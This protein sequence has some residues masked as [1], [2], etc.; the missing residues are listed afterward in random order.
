MRNVQSMI[1]GVLLSGGVLFLS[2]CSSSKN[3][4]ENIDAEDRFALGKQEFDE[5]DYLDAIRDF[6]IVTIQFQGSA[7]AD[8]AQYYLAESYYERHEY[9]LAASEYETLIRRMR[10]SEL[11]PLAQYKRAMCY[12]KLSPRPAL[13]QQYTK[14]AIDSFQE[15]IEYNPTHQFAPDG[16]ARIQELN[17]KLALK[18]YN[19]ARLYVRMD[20]HKS[21]QFY[22]EH[23]LERYHDSDWADDAHIGLVEVLIARKRYPEANEMVERFFIR[24]PDSPLMIR[25]ENLRNDVNS[26]LN[27]NLD[28]I[29]ETASPSKGKSTPDVDSYFMQNG[30]QKR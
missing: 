25:A 2:S 7:L 3:A 28:Q 17:N 14:K 20:R 30:W 5:G 27:Q 13:D 21:A 9:I 23:L 11:V 8:D 16:E 22:F 29:P 26:K 12:Y 1:V 10:S 19:T 15:F 6:Q 18:M 4:L 24:F